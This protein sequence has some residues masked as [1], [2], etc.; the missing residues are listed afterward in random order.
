[1]LGFAAGYAVGGRDHRAAGTSQAAASQPTAS[2]P[3]QPAGKQ[4]SEQTVKPSA[5]AQP[6]SV[7]PPVP[8]D[9][10]AAGGAR[11]ATEAPKPRTEALP[12]SGTLT[13]RSTPPGAAVT[14][15][16]RWRG[17]TPLTLEKLPFAR[18]VVRVVQPGYAVEREE[19]ALSRTDASRTL[20]VRMR[21]ERGAAPARSGAPARGSAAPSSGTTRPVPLTGTLFVASNPPG[22]RVFVDGKPVGTAPIRVPDV[23]IGAHV[24]RMELPDHRTWS[25]STRIVAGQDV[26]VTGSLE[27]IR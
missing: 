9:A 5:S 3:T 14:L 15:N 26:R 10:P 23:H 16:G 6:P 13:V 11:P 1:L 24:V 12:T 20:S 22:A 17:R 21:P 19:V 8:G 7:A 2:A 27:R 25:T 4:W 18:Y